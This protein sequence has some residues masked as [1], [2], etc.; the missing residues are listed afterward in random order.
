M[1]TTVPSHILAAQTAW[2]AVYE[3]LATTAEGGAAHRRRLL[4]LSRRITAH[5]CWQSPAGTPAARVT[6]KKLART[7]T[8]VRP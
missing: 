4:E 1:T 3:Q 2:Y 7:R 6:L 5:P 8:Q